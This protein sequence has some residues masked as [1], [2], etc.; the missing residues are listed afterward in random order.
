MKNI[1][2]ILLTAILGYFL[3]LGIAEF[4]PTGTSENAPL[5]CM[6]GG[7]IFM[8]GKIYIFPYFKAKIKKALPQ[9]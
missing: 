1:G 3:G 7:I 9:R 2:L 6:R 5:I 4:S 8:I